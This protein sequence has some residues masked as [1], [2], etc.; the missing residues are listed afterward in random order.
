MAFFSNLFLH[1][2]FSRASISVQVNNLEESEQSVV[3]TYEGGRRDVL[4]RP[5]AFEKIDMPINLRFGSPG[6]RDKG[7]VVKSVDGARLAATA[8]GG[9]VTSTDTYQIY[10]ASCVSAKQ[11]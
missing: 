5:R 2:L 1:P 10:T 7:V 9:E 3:I 4:L 11:V 6:E 8:F